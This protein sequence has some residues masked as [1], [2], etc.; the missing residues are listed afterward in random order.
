LGFKST[1]K[2]T[3]KQIFPWE[4]QGPVLAPGCKPTSWKLGV[5]FLLIWFKGTNLMG[6][7]LDLSII[8][9]NWNTKK[10]LLD[11]LASVYETVTRISMQVWLVDNAS[12]DGSVEAVKRF[13]PDVKIIQNP[14][15]MGF[16]AANNRA[17]KRMSGRYA[18]LLNT[19]TVLTTGAVEAIYDFMENTP[20]A[21]MACGQLLNPDGSKQNSIANFPGL[22]SLLLN[23]TLLRM[24]LPGRYPSKRKEYKSPVEVDSCIGACLMV[25]KKTMDHVGLLDDD[26][27][28]FFEET[29]WARRI[30]QSGWKIY[31]V[32]AA[33]IIHFQGR[34][35][36][37]NVRSRILFYRS[38]YIYFKKWHRD[39]CG[40]VQVIIFFRLLIN[41][42]LS[43]VG[44]IGTLGLHEGIRTKV[45]T[46]AKLIVWHLE[47]C[48][49][50][51][52]V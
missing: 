22:P 17:F 27:F 11:C 13:Y 38:R 35:V 43:L 30:K 32:P 4:N 2:L 49:D 10:L 20:D 46:Y 18:V 1:N 34:S 50:E 44:F 14:R 36:G 33:R 16:A 28:F 24:L 31:F 7:E 5:G 52:Q 15:N 42:A 6:N 29:D 37:R 26:Y 39:I 51:R 3:A 12:T 41:A 47:G 48:P 9:V 21:G 8:I 23:E 45:D 25:R 19:D 40:L